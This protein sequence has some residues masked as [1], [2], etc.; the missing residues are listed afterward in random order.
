[1]IKECFPLP[2][3]EVQLDNPRVL[4]EWEAVHADLK[5]KDR[6]QFKEGWTT[7]KLSDQTF[8]EN[9]IETYKLDEFK[10]E[11]STHLANYLL[12]IDFNNPCWW[13]VA[14]CW[15][16]SYEKNHYAHIHN[17]SPS[18]ISGCYYV[19]SNTNDGNIFFLN[20]NRIMSSTLVYR[21]LPD[22]LFVRPRPGTLILFP[23]WLDHGVEP[24]KTDDERVSVAFNIDF[25]RN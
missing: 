22:R 5:S 4:A 17:H 18:D 14:G 21:T 11:L 7:H 13:K 10:K 25:S 9:L 20:P 6:F 19:K 16:T 24:N 2:I 3:Y 1:M 15:M 8:K 23:G 12:G